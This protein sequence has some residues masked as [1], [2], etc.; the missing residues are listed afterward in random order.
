MDWFVL[1]PVGIKSRFCN[2]RTPVYSHLY[3]YGVTSD[4]GVTHFL[5]EKCEKKMRNWDGLVDSLTFM[6]NLDREPLIDR[7]PYD[8]L[9]RA[10]WQLGRHV[11]YVT[12]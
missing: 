2:F 9:K 12:L 1:L 10:L 8:F 7:P 5:C 11:N 6:K 4:P 3:R